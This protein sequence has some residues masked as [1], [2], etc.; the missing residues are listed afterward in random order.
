[1]NASFE[2]AEGG[3][4]RGRGAGRWG[5]VVG[6]LALAGVVLVITFVLSFGSTGESFYEREFAWLFWIN[7]A[8]AALLLGVVGYV[9]A[10]LVTRVRAGRFGSRLLIKLA[11]ILTLVGVL[12]GAV[13]YTVS[14]QFAERSIAS[15]F[16]VRVAQALDAGVALGRDTLDTLKSDLAGK[17]RVAAARLA[18]QGSASGPLALERLREQLGVEELALVDEG[19]QWLLSSAA[20]RGELAIERPPAMLLRQARAAGPAR[21]TGWRKARPRRASA[22]WWRCRAMRSLCARPRAASCGWCSRC[23]ARWPPMRWRCRRPTASTSSARSRARRC[24]ACTWAR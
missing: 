16:D 21:S 3:G 9:V 4:R 6:V 19:G 7:V 24:A 22:S 20:R 18:E 8:I 13:V 17:A 14:W 11:G 5:W 23:R 2:P 12:P 15:W 10:R 1:M